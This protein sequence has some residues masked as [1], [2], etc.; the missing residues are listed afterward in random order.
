MQNDKLT[1]LCRACKKVHEFNALNMEEDQG[2]L[3][4]GVGW[5]I[6]WSDF[7]ME[8]PDLNER[9]WERSSTIPVVGS[10]RSVLVSH[11]FN[12]TVGDTIWSLFQP[13]LS[14]FNGWDEHPEEINNSA[15]VKFCFVSILSRN[16]EK[17]W[18][19][20]RIEDVLLLKE[21][22]TRLKSRE[23]PGTSKEFDSYNNSYIFANEEWL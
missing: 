19:V 13:A 15:M 5:E 22:D 20:I 6:E 17:A 4:S 23:I 11:P 3:I 2:Y 8:V 14:S 12:M 21:A 9:H 7:M 18:I 10:Y 16:E 1:F